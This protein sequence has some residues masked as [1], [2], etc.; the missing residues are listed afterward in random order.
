MAEVEQLLTALLNHFETARDAEAVLVASA[1][2]PVLPVG[3]LV[4]F[5]RMVVPLVLATQ[6]ALAASRE[7]WTGDRGVIV[8]AM[9]NRHA[10]EPRPEDLFQTGTLAR[11][12][13]LVEPTNSE[14]RLVVEG[15]HR[16]RLKQITQVHP[17]IRAA[18]EVLADQPAE[19]PEI[20]GLLRA[21]RS[22]FE[23]ASALS[24]TVPSDAVVTAT[25][26]DDPGQ[27]SDIVAAY[28][29]LKL[30]EK[31]AVLE[32]ADVSERLRTVERTLERELQ[33]L[34]VEHEIHQ[35]VRATI[36]DSQREFYLREQMRAIQTELGEREGIYSE[37]EEYRSKIEAAGMSA[38]AR[39]KALQELDRLERM[40]AASPE[41]S[42]IRTYLDWLIALPWQASTED[43]LDIGA[44]EEIMEQDHYGLRKVKDRV[45]EFLAVHKIVSHTKGP[46]LCFVGPPGVGKTSIG[47]SIARAM[48]RKFIRVSLG[49]VR[50]EAEIRGH[51]RT[52][53]GAMPGRII[54]T[55]RRVASNNPVFMIDEI[56]KIGLDFRGDPSSA[57]LE[58]LDPEQNDSFQDHYLEVP[59]DLSRVFFITTGNYTEPIPPALLDRMEIIEFPGYIEEEKVQIAKRF[60]VPK[61][62]KEHGLTG[63]HVR[64]P[65][66]AL[67]AL[68]RH[69]TSEAGVRELERQIAAVCRKVARRVASGEEA[70]AA[71]TPQVLAEL[72]GPPRYRREEYKR[73]DQV[74][75]A[76]GLAFTYD[77]GD[78][79]AVEVAVL[80]GSGDLVLTGRL[81]E[82]MKESAQAAV[83][84]ARSRAAEL[85][86]NADYFTHH[87]IHVHVPSGAVPKEGP[88]AGIA[89]ATA[90]ISAMTG[91]KIRGDVAMTGEVTLHGRVL[92][93]AG[94]R[95]KVL[96]AHR[97]G[98]K[99]VILPAENEPDLSELTETEAKVREDVDF[100]FVTHMQ[101]VLNTALL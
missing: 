63:K 48:G 98:M 76:N 31:Q 96:A 37:V 89:I 91:R 73:E 60:L 36:E 80:E 11:A 74:G 59:F 29:D 78:V 42:V 99:L 83:G 55:I 94:I 64:F 53:V 34:R 92:R 66:T 45:L 27:L 46:I 95:E 90:L 22:M 2:L 58:V 38:E 21:V 71:V 19:G 18:Y 30:E 44:A 72:L 4:L 32:A 5:P 100:V 85:E 68:V 97:A 17:C 35:R 86:L 79:I 70:T 77:G 62:R 67:R 75:V 82:V 24:R 13:Q 101:Q 50:D 10:G 16:V 39:E 93:V 3:D 47:R 88:S 51:R 14:P 7:A 54:Q 8:V 33:I 9:R 57:L 56:D 49:G 26:V 12:V 40:P 81:G 43:K 41:V 87:D 52:Y 6:A 84:Y 61:Q 1:D 65:E 15:L 23:E 28:L 20:E 25:N 69:Y